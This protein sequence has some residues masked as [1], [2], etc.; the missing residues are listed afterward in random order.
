MGDF[1][2]ANVANMRWPV[3]L[4]PSLVDFL[5][6]A[7]SKLRWDEQN[8]MPHT[9]VNIPGAFTALEKRDQRIF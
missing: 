1:F 3:E 2:L 5:M 6:L 8:I 9:Q 7:I 4:N